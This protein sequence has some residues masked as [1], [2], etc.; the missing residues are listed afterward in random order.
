MGRIVVLGA[1]MCGLASAMLLARDG[2]DVTVLERDAEAARESPDAA[3]ESW[4]RDGVV[5]FRQAHYLQAR[6]RHVLDAE[7]P[8]VRDELVAAGAVRFDPLGTMPPFITDRGDRAGDERFVTLTA[9]RPTLEHVFARAAEA[10]PRVQ[11]RRG[12]TVAGLLTGASAFDGVPHVTGVRTQGGEE[13]VGDLVVDAMGRRSP[14]PSWLRECGARDLHEEA[15][16]CGFIYYTR[17]FRS[18]DGHAPQPRMGLLSPIGSFSILTLPGDSGTWSVTL[19]ASSRDR[20]LKLLRHVDRWTAV[21]A[22]CPM[23]AHWLDGEP[24]TGVLAMGGVIDRYRR[25]VAN[26]TFGITGLASVGDAWACT[27]PSLGRGI[28]LGLVHAARL[29]DTVR[30]HLDEPRDFAEA[31]DAVTEEELTPWYRAT[32]AVDRAR[33]AQID[34]LREGR[35]PAPPADPGSASAAALGV[36]MLYDAEAFRGFADIVGCLALPQEVFA[37]PG[38]AERVHA[39]ATEAELPP[40][41]G[42]GREELLRMLA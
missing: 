34:A 3:W 8:D 39:L 17:F 18:R 25:L 16:D 10:E 29:R 7:L 41:P 2:H 32:V 26:G 24:V 14:L 42:P 36:A 19:Y 30:E 35:D 37:R 33:L 9:R 23:H 22:A 27:N 6:G 12:V 5:Q 11:I 15:E 21:V 4:S 31:W 20:P 13:V 28:A 1:G 40:P 38:L